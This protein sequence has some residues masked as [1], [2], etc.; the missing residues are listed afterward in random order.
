MSK[1][2]IHENRGQYEVAWFED[3]ELGAIVG[4]ERRSRTWKQLTAVLTKKIESLKKNKHTDLA[5]EEFEFLVVELVA[6]EFIQELALDAYESGSSGIQFRSMGPA[7]K[8]LRVARARLKLAK[9]EWESSAPVPDWAT[10]AIAAG[11]KAPKG[12]KP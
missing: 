9:I 8:L 5:F 6:A 10:K 1:I 4:Q 11:W 12:W 7:M 2:D 3:G